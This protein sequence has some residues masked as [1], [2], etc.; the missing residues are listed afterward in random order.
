[1]VR[2]Q[3][4]AGAFPFWE[5]RCAEGTPSPIF[6]FMEIGAFHVAKYGEQR[7]YRQHIKNKGLRREFLRRESWFGVGKSVW[8]K[9][10]RTYHRSNH[11][12]RMGQCPAAAFEDDN[13]PS[14]FQWQC[15]SAK[16]GLQVR[17][18]RSS[19]MDDRY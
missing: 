9:S 4:T 15:T 16:A 12:S 2:I 18:S 6:V 14:S 1:M 10:G 8:L 11:L 13:S 7:S 17:G 5:I 19:V 3:S